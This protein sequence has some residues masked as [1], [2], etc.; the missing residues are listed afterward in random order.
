MTQTTFEA[1]GPGCWLW[2]REVCG[3][4]RPE[5][6]GRV[7]RTAEPLARRWQATIDGAVGHGLT[8]LAAIDAAER[9]ATNNCPVLKKKPR[10]PVNLVSR[11]L[12]EVEGESGGS[13]A[14][15]LPVPAPARSKRSWVVAGLADGFEKHRQD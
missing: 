7:E 4:S 11:W 14:R 1:F 2:R 6:A 10:Q 5:S 9:A 12:A 13:T 8:R 3:Q 15:G